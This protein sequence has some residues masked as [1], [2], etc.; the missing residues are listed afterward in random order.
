MHR[1][2]QPQADRDV[3]TNPETAPNLIYDGIGVNEYL[4]QYRLMKEKYPSIMDCPQDKPYYDGLSCISCPDP[5]RYFNLNTR[6]CQ[7][8]PLDSRYNKENREC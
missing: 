6:Q 8:C 3:Q 7:L 2:V 4:K 1:C 5:F